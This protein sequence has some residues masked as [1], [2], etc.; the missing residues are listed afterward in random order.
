MAE[1]IN[2][3]MIVGR[4]VRDSELK[5]T[6]SGFAIT[7]LSLA[8]NGR[9]KQGEQ[10]IDEASFFEATILGKRGESLSQYLTKGSQVAVEGKLKQERWEKD[11]QKR[12]KIVI[13]VENIQLLGGKQDGMTKGQGGHNANGS[14]PNNSYTPPQ[15]ST[16]D[17]D[18]DVPF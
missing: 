15:N 4:L 9:K 17:Y 11:G 7:S 3:V 14:L 8:S 13:V 1:D 18:D 6:P 10:W 16:P 5:F 12:S 2:K